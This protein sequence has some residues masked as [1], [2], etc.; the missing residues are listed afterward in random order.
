MAARAAAAGDDDGV[1]APN[2]VVGGGTVTEGVAIAETIAMM[3]AA[4]AGVRQA[5][6]AAVTATA[7][8]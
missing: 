7:E 8:R 2:G 5:E 3:V 4:V 6:L 1:G